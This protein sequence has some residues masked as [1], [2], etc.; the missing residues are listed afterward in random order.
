[1]TDRSEQPAEEHFPGLGEPP[2]PTLEEDQSTAPRPEE[3]I[4]DQLRSEPAPDGRPQQ[5]E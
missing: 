3:E 4:A 1:M 5:D 2:V